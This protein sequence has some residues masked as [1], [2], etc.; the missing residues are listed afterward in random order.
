MV[1][2]EIFNHE[3]PHTTTN[4]H[5]DAGPPPT[6]THTHTLPNCLITTWT[7]IVACDQ[8][9]TPPLQADSAARSCLVPPAMYQARNHTLHELVSSV[10]FTVRK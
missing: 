6:H 1:Q 10:G 8:C 4:T 9:G 3:T 2:Q 5:R 7:H